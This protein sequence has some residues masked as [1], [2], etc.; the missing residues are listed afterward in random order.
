LQLFV[1]LGGEISTVR[2]QRAQHAINGT[3]DQILGFH[4]FDI[5]LLDDR[6]NIGKSFQALI[7]L[8]RHG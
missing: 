6:K 4:I 5:I 2:V 3:V 1:K 7:I 8:T